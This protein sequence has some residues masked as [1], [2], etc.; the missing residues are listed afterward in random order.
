MLPTSWHAGNLLELS[1]S[2]WKTGVLHTAVKLDLFSALHR[3]PASAE[4]LAEKLKISRDG[5]ARLLNALCA[6]GL[7]VYDNGQY[8][9]TT[10]ADQFLVTSSKGYIGYMI[11]HHYHLVA[12]WIRLAESVQ[13]GQALDFPEEEDPAELESFLMGMF[14]TAMNVAPLIVPVVDLS[15]RKHLL[16][17][18]GGPGTYSIH[19]CQAHPELSAVVF[20]RPTTRPFFEKTVHRFQLESRIVFQPGDYREDAIKGPYDV[21]WLSHVLH[22]ENPERCA[23]LLN[24]AAAVLPPG[25]LMIIHE[26]ILNDDQRSP[27]FATLFSL[28][29]LLHT[30]GG[31]SYTDGQLREMLKTAGFTDIQRIPVQT[32]NES[33]L[34]QAVK[35]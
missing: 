13:T 24:K 15:T 19:F 26:F 33:G 2:Y 1:G 10:P 3:A 23:E 18:G 22:G 31:R 5:L 11:M 29:M 16:D 25:G 9:N 14:N 12:S 7:L 28:N 34:L 21:V 32:P 35:A 4:T 6:L 20:D 17:L 27:L 30:D 8:A